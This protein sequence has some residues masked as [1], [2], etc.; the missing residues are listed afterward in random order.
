MERKKERIIR[1]GGGERR[2][3]NL[4]TRHMKY[5]HVPQYYYYYDNVDV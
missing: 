5:V 3:K 4:H 1:Y 2:N